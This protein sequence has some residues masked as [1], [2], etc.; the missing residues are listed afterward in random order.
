MTTHRPAR[1]RLLA[2]LAALVLAGCGFRLRGP[3]PLPFE[4]AH[5]AGTVGGELQR[6]IRKRIGASGSTRVSDTRNGAEVV[7][8]LLGAGR[9]KNI[10]GLSGA[11]KVREYEFVQNL[12]FRLLAADGREL[13]PETRLSTSREATWDDSAILA[14]DQEEALLFADMEEE[15]VRQLMRR[16]EAARSGG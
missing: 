7:L 3:R 8:E 11:G 2:G 5:V 14:K 9:E 16:L 13:I 1:R 15:L 12:R 4:S 6:R 10:I